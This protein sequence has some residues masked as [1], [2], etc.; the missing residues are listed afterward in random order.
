MWRQN[1]MNNIIKIHKY[2]HTN[3]IKYKISLKPVEKSAA[4]NF[5]YETVLLYLPFACNGSERSEDRAWW[6][7]SSTWFRLW[8]TRVWLQRDVE[9][10][11]WWSCQLNTQAVLRCIHALLLQ[12]QNKLQMY[13]LVF[14]EE[15]NN[16]KNCERFFLATF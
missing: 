5:I 1:R 6:K 16:L 13:T 8:E 15:E 2:T 7:G 12:Y 11:P 9:L 4:Q 3:S 10:R 14:I